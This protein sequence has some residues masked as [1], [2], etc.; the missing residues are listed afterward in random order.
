[1]EGKMNNL[2]RAIVA[3]LMLVFAVSLSGRLHAQESST[4]L[5]PKDTGRLSLKKNAQSRDYQ[6]REVEGEEKLVGPGDTLWGILVRE[7]GLPEQKFGQYIVIIRGLNPQIKKVDVLRVGDRVFIPLRPD[8][9]LD[10]TSVSAQ[11]D[12][13][14]TPAPRGAIREYRVKPGEHLYQILREQLEVTTDREVASYYAL[15]K[16]LNPERKDWDALLGGDVIRLPVMGTST[17]TSVTTLKARPAIESTPAK[18]IEPSTPVV[19]VEQ[20]NQAKVAKPYT[21]PPVGLDYARHLPAREHVALA[22]QVVEVLGNEIRQEGQESLHLQGGTVRVDRASYP[23]VYNPRLHQR[24]ILDPEEKIPESLKNKLTDSIAQTAVLPVSRTAS[25]QESVN[26]LLS[27]LGYQSL[28]AGK[29][30]IIQEGGVSIE[31]KG[32]WMVLAPEESRKAQEIIVIALTDNPQDIP[33]Y[34]RKELSARGLLLKDILLPRTSGD[35][36]TPEKS[37]TVTATAKQWPRDKKELIDAILFAYGVP[38]GVAES[39]S[40]E[41][42]D[43][44]RVD[45][46]YDRIFERNDKRIGIFFQP[47]EAET[48]RLLQEQERIEVIDFD[49]S[50]L[51]SREIMTRLLTELGE[52][53]SYREHRFSASASK[54]RLNISAWG[55]LLARRGMFVTDREIPQSLQRF[56]FEKG[57]EIVYF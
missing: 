41:L 56:F 57:L 39:V 27:R 33:D 23:V 32:N 29:P 42:G 47:L 16:D 54:D 15:V 55:F 36:N 53:T 35:S 8:E 12:V 50:R 48:K 20:T 38:F 11:A 25:L 40:V 31:A 14:R 30:V 7:K 34:L 2:G 9:V 5:T 17:D 28:P 44:L 19:T 18:S 10:G 37:K 43:G 52:Q 22:A 21:P 3:A 4:G 6:G 45:L 1:M 13:P 46:R 26:D 49:L 51:E 24:V